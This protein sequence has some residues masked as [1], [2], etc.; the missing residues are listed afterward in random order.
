MTLGETRHLRD[1]ESGTPPRVNRRDRL[2]RQPTLFMWIL[3]KQLISAFAQDTEAL[4]S[5]SVELSQTCAQSLMRRSKHSPAKTYLREWKAG[6]LMR[7]RSGAIS[8]H[9]LGRTFRDWWI[10][11]LVATRVSHSVPQASEPEQTTQDTSGPLFQPELLSCD[12][13]SVSLKTSKDISRWGCPTLSKTWDAWVIEQRGAYSVRL[14]AARLIKESAYSS[15]Q[16]WPTPNAADSLQGGTT[17]GNRKSPNL[18]I[19]AFGPAD[20]VNP[21]THGSRPEWWGTPAAND[22]NKTPHCEINSKQAGLVRSVG[23]EEAKAWATPRCS[24]A[25]DKQEDSGKHRLG[26]QAQ[27]GTTGKLNPRWVETL[28]GLPVGWTMPSCQS[29]ATIALTSCASSAT[30]SSQLQQP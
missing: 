28:M 24:M 10:S 9:F 11:S 21:N 6:N 22:A 17:Q 20:P 19:A 5:D 14:S 13:A 8:S 29:P 2:E 3:P 26:E 23:R 18:S 15:V 16:S 1:A 30:E 27:N 7:L 25:Q 4:T 12:Q